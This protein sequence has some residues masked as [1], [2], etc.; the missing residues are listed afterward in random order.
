[1]LH[2]SSKAWKKFSPSSAGENMPNTNNEKETFVDDKYRQIVEE[3]IRGNL[4]VDIPNSTFEHARF[5]T[6][7]LLGRASREVRIL[8]GSLN[9]ALYGGPIKDIL[10][11]LAQRGV[12][13]KIIIWHEVTAGAK[14]LI[15]N[16]GDNIKFKCAHL[17]EEAKYYSQTNHFLVVDA[18]AFRFENPHGPQE[19]AAGSFAVTGIANFNNSVRAHHLE[20]VF[21]SIWSR[22]QLSPIA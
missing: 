5:L 13:I 18:Q 3:A 4:D 12:C 21:D 22:L 6:E 10:L 11:R 16:L 20:G 15:N 8:S 17:P 7:K 9:E 14:K 19:E 1:M 2:T